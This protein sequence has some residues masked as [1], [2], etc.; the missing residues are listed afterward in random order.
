M[1]VIYTHEINKLK[2]FDEDNMDIPALV[3]MIKRSY[4]RYIDDCVLKEKITSG[5]C[6]FL[7]ALNK[8]DNITQTQLAES[9]KVSEGLA[10]R[11]L[12]SLEKN[13][14]I[15]REVDLEN[16]RKKIISITPEGRSIASKLIKYQE[17]WENNV[18]SFLNEEE[19]KKFKSILKLALINSI[20]VE[21]GE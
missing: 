15:K 16:K 21:N 8:K 19:F 18:F 14:L 5:E 6:P 2:D 12:K 7:L 11:V 13:Y 17:N 1:S 20:G 3:G 4:I 10:T 9:L